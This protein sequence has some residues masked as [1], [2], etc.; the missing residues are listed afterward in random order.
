MEDIHL[1]IPAG[2]R[3]GLVGPNGAGKSTLLMLF[4]LLLRPTQGKLRVL[5]ISASERIPVA[6]RRQIAV[7]FQQPR[8]LTGTVWD[9]VALPLRLR[10]LSRRDEQDRTAFWLERFDLTHLARQPVKTLSGGE[11]ARLQLARAL[12]MQPALLL[13]DEPFAAVDATSRSMFKARLKAALADIDPTVV[14]I[15]HDFS[16]F[17]DLTDQ[18]AV[19]LNGRIVEQGPTAALFKTSALVQTLFP[20]LNRPV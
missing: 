3:W 16:D 6:I 14:M 18:T 15:S 5:G 8:F 20:T 12:S 9:N 10:G 7:S 4:A 19:V 1:F 17:L 2:T 11:Q 13:L